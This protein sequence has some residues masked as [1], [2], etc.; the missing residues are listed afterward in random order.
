MDMTSDGSLNTGEAGMPGSLTPSS[1][2]HREVNLN[3]LLHGPLF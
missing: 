3:L 2:H 1:S